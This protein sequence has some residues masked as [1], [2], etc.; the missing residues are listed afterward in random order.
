MEQIVCTQTRF[1]MNISY[2]DAN[3]LVPEDCL[4]TVVCS[5]T[6]VIHESE[7]CKVQNCLIPFD[8][9]C[10]YIL[11]VALTTEIDN[12]TRSKHMTVH[13]IRNTWNFVQF[14]M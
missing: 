4:A 5:D 1:I 2:V 7:L 9:D 10:T 3:A 14:H 12:L 8:I 11:V 13:L 6:V